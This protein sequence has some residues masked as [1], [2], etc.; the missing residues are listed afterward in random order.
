MLS[1]GVADIALIP[2]GPE[3]IVSFELGTSNG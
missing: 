3:A 2:G 1:G